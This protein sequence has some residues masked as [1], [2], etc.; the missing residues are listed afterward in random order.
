MK[1]KKILFVLIFVMLILNGCQSVKTIGRDLLAHNLGIVLA[2]LLIIPLLSKISKKK[3]ILLTKKVVYIQYIILFIISFLVSSIFY[4]NPYP[5]YNFTL[6]YLME[7]L[8]S[9]ILFAPYVLLLTLVFI[10]IIPKKY[11]DFIPTYI[12][13]MY[14]ISTTLM[15]I[16]NSGYAALLSPL[17]H[18]WYISPLSILLIIYI[19]KRNI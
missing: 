4:R 5:Q 8:I 15:V 1:N 9:I 2:S 3:R 6:D 17:L 16:T 7:H 12:I 13:V 11:V 10:I 18:W 14:F 19:R